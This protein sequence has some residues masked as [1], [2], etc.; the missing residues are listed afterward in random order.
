MKIWL[1]RID[2]AA[3]VKYIGVADAIAEDIKQR[4]IKPGD[5]LPAQRSIAE[6]LNIDLTTVTRAINEATKRGLI[7][8]RRGSGSFVALTTFSH[9]N[10]LKLTD[11]KPLDLSM[12]NPPN[13]AG[14]RIENEIAT[15][16]Q[17]ICTESQFPIDQLSYQETAGNPQDRLMASK[18]LDQKIPNISSD[19]ILITSGAHSALFSILNHLKEAGQRAI[20]APDFSYPGLRSIAEKLQFELFGIEMDGEGIIPESLEKLCQRHPVD[21]L[22]LV[23]NIDNP[24]TAT[25][26]IKRREQIVAIAKQYGL[27]IIEDDPYAIFLDESLPSLY[28]LYHEKTWHIATLSKCISPALRLAYVV[29]PDVDN[30]LSLAEEIRVSSLMAPPL[31]AAV[32]SHWIKTGRITE[33][34]SAIKS[35]NSVRQQL[36]ATIFS[37]H[38]ILTYPTGPHF[39]LQLPKRMSALDFSE[40]A[41]RIGV[42][43]VPSTAFVTERCRHQSVRVSLGVSTEHDSLKIGLRLLEKVLTKPRP[44]MKSII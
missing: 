27:T 15:A 38:N 7:E 24:T 39:W 28:S 13:P 16:L 23:P 33:I 34:T 43:I 32:V 3:R 29:A 42:S 44:R 14:F 11:G 21:I 31:M 25:L 18:W 17:I 8:T 20:A 2:K 10:S 1:P 26:P 41:E 40:Q 36:A 35:E 9:Y 30:A 5:K 37:K 6:S 22:Y 19:K 4:L 12:N